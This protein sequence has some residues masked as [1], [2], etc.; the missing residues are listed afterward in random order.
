MLG[1]VLPDL[2]ATTGFALLPGRGVERERLLAEVYEREPWRSV[3]RAAHSALAAGLLAAVARRRPR[4]RALASGWAGHLV[5]D[6]ASHADDAWPPLWPVTRARWPSPV[7]YWQEEHHARAW[8]AGEC[9][10]LL[11]SVARDTG[12]TRRA[13]GLLALGLAAAPLLA[14]RGESLWTAAGLRP[15]PRRV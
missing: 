8:S 10:A 14:P 5:V 4:A 6:Y 1:G 13:A 9:L 11:A 7:S 2:P 3:Q 12:T 15:T